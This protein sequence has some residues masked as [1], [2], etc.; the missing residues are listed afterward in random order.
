[1]QEY[2]YRLFLP[3]NGID[4]VK[5]FYKKDGHFLRCSGAKCYR[6]GIEV[7]CDKDAITYAIKRAKFVKG[8][9]NEF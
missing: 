6:F 7:R 4:L 5:L 8:L 9:V 1:M 2:D 3:K